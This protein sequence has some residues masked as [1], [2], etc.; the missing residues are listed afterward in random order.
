MQCMWKQIRKT[1]QRGIMQKKL[2]RR[3]VNQRKIHQRKANRR[4]RNKGSMTIELCFIMPM[5]ICVIFVAV[6]MMFLLMNKSVIQC[7]MYWALYGKEA[8]IEESDVVVDAINEVVAEKLDSGLLFSENVRVETDI[9]EVGKINSIAG[10]EGTRIAISTRY[11][12]KQIGMMGNLSGEKEE[13]A[14]KISTD[15]RN[16]ADNLRRW[17]LYGA[18][19]PK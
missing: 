10:C 17:Q 3:K 19:I 16:T 7:E 9:E 14:L 12:P 18:G 15:I 5:V 6:N 8:Y 4:N 11:Q 2:E 13:Y 1:R